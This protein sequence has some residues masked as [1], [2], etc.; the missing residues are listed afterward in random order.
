MFLSNGG[1]AK[2]GSIPQL[3]SSNSGYKV[4]TSIYNKLTS[5]PESTTQ[6]DTI[7]DIESEHVYF[8]F[9]PRYNTNNG[10][11][12]SFKCY[13]S[14]GNLLDLY[15]ENMTY[16]RDRNYSS[17]VDYTNVKMDVFNTNSFAQTYSNFFAN[18]NA[19]AGMGYIHIWSN[20]II[21]SIYVEF[22]HHNY[23]I[24]NKSTLS[25]ILKVKK[26]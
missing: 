23:N 3:N 11:T 18:G 10:V 9:N 25:P 20:G 19:E 5:L 7:S 24:Y 2:L 6:Y 22:Q 14:L 16:Q 4:I 17:R 13:D 1:S 8:E 26:Y 12:F 15:I 21:E